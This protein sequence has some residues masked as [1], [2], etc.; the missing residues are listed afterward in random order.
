MGRLV[1]DISAPQIVFGTGTPDRMV[2]FAEVDQ[3]DAYYLAIDATERSRQL[4]PRVTGGHARALVPLFGPGFFGIGLPDAI[5]WYLEHGTN[6]FTMKSLAGKTIPMWVPDE[7]GSLRQKNPKIRRRTTEDGRLQVLIFRKAAPIGS[8]KST[9]KRNR[10]TGA[11]ETTTTVRSYPGAP[12]RIGRRQP[13]MPWTPSGARGGAIGPGNVGVRWRH[14][15]LKPIEMINAGLSEAAFTAGLPL[16][17]I[18]A[19]TGAGLEQLIE[20]TERTGWAGGL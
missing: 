5:V 16:N 14:P 6:P 11:I 2:M 8:R 15:G 20:R 1:P 10:V 12:G 3:Q 4:M 19:T 18:Y 17:T 9:A 13:G 7:D